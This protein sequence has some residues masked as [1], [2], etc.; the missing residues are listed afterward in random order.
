MSTQ[1][2]T[3]FTL[4][5]I[6]QLLKVKDRTYPG[7]MLLN[8]IG[9]ICIEQK[10]EKAE[11]CLLSFLNDP[12]PGFRAISFCYLFCA[13]ELQE[14]H[15]LILAEFRVNPANQTLNKDIDIMI[16]KFKEKFG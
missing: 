7:C 3:N 12:N 6:L 5:E 8:E 10:D 9:M 4:K 2:Q 11:K 13:K 15:N 14:K 1:R 16:I